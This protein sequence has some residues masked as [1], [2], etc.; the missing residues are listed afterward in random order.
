MIDWICDADDNWNCSGP[1]SLRND[2]VDCPYS[3]E[4]LQNNKNLED[5]LQ[6]GL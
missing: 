4:E 6:T 2:I 3:D 5:R 1:C